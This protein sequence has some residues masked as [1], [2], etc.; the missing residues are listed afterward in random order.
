MR[1]LSGISLLFFLVS[2]FVTG[3]VVRVKGKGAPPPKPDQ[4][5]D[6][7]VDARSGWDKLGERWVD[8]AVDK[9]V[10]A[11]TAKE[12]RYQKIMI[13]VE[14]STVDLYDIDI[15]FGDSSHFSPGTRLTFGPNSTS[16]VIDLPGGER[17]IRKVEFKYA[18]LPGGGRAQVELWAK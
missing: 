16:R 14:K 13:V 15:T 12:G 10:I 7:A 1:R 6:A 17:V 9:D 18:N 11:V 8:G 2:L 3:C 4:R 5:R